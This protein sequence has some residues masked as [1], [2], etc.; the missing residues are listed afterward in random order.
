MQN[1]AHVCERGHW[2]LSRDN[3]GESGALARSATVFHQGWLSRQ[4]GWMQNAKT[5]AVLQESGLGY[6]VHPE[7]DPSFC[8]ALDLPMPQEID[9]ACLVNGIVGNLKVLCFDLHHRIGD[10]RGDRAPVAIADSDVHAAQNFVLAQGDGSQVALLVNQA[11]RSGA[12]RHAF[13]QRGVFSVVKDIPAEHNPSAKIDHLP[14]I[15]T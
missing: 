13:R 7:T 6:A 4:A 2:L 10:D 11:E 8:I 5:D 12:Q 14:S 15:L 1:G 9:R 3:L